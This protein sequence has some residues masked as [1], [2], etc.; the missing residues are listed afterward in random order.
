MKMKYM[1]KTNLLMCTGHK[2]IIAES[3]AYAC[4]R[5]WVST[6]VFLAGCLLTRKT[7]N[8]CFFKKQSKTKTATNAQRKHYDTDVREKQKDQMRSV[9]RLSSTPLSLWKC[10]VLCVRTH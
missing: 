6:P 9:G 3:Y 4:Y 10:C 5:Q 7:Q 8:L 1:K 2:P